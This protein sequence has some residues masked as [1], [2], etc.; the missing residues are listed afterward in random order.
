MYWRTAETA[1]Y[2][3][4]SVPFRSEFSYRVDTHSASGAIFIVGF[5]R[6]IVTQSSSREKF[7]AGIGYAIYVSAFGVE[8]SPQEGATA[9][10]N[11]EVGPINTLLDKKE[12]SSGHAT[13]PKPF[14]FDLSR[15]APLKSLIGNLKLT[16]IKGLKHI[17]DGSHSHILVGELNKKKVVI[18]ILKE[19]SVD[20]EIAIHEY[21]VEKDVLCRVDHPNVVE[22]VGWGDFPRRFLV[23]EYLGGDT[24]SHIL[25]KHLSKPG[26]QIFHKPS[27][28]YLQLLQL[29]RTI[30]SALGHLHSGAIE[31]ATIVHRDLK[32]DNIAFTQS[33]VVKIID[34]GL[35]TCVNAR[36]ASTDTYRMTGNTG[37]KRYMAPEVALKRPYNETADVYSF[38][39]ILWQMARDK[40]PFSKMGVDEFLQK[41]ARDGERPKLDK[42]WPQRFSAL[43]VACWDADPLNRPSFANVVRKLEILIMAEGGTPSAL[44]SG[45]TAP[46]SR[47]VK[48]ASA[49]PEVSKSSNCLLD[50]AVKPLP[51]PPSKL[52]PPEVTS[53]APA[54][55]L[56]TPDRYNI[57]SPKNKNSTGW[58]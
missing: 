5:S 35:C 39:I 19:E 8:R 32:P 9:V 6:R 34:F 30:A 11:T 38:G 14:V 4:S 17:A 10:Q 25:S 18:K 1:L 58:F 7:L 48:M 53:R 56:P 43:L 42:A 52:V 26:I 21:A 37:S 31:G 22:A 40:V 28:T 47:P 16:D 41:V 36:D 50:N 3:D 23:L 44:P 55:P 13:G 49:S 27:F 51:Y 33:G 15:V 12:S 45:Q 54:P 20:N 57:S 2:P 24:L 29:A 46:A